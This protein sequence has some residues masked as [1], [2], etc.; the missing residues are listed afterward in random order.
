MS[1]NEEK[2]EKVV[3]RYDR[4][5]QRRQA[6]K[7][8]EKRSQ[9]ITKGVCGVIVL[10]V[11][12]FIASFPIRSYMATHEAYIT[13]NGEKV[14]RAEFDYNY[15]NTVNTYINQMGSYLGYMGLDVN[16]DFS[17]QEYADGLTWKDNFD[18]MTVEAL[19]TNKALKA[20]AEANGF[21]YDSSAE[22]EE[23]KSSLK[24]AA[25]EAGV[26]SGKYVKQVYGQYATV[27]AVEG[28]VRESA[29]L[30]AYSNYL[31]E[32]FAP[33]DEEIQ[34]YYDENSA[35]YET[36]SYYMSQFIAEVGDDATEE[37]IEN[38]MNDASSD[39]LEAVNDIVASGDY[40]ENQKKSDVDEAIVNWL[41]YEERQEGDQTVFPDEENHT[42]YALRFVNRQKDEES[43]VNAHVIMT[44]D[45]GQ[46]ILDEWSAGEATEASFINLW[47]EHSADTSMPDGLYKNIKSSGLDAE[48][49]GWLFDGARQAGDTSCI[50]VESTGTNYVVYYV[51]EGDPSWMADIKST[52]STDAKSNYINSLTENVTVEDPKGNLNYLKVQASNAAED[53]SGD[54]VVDEET[55]EDVSGDDVVDEETQGDVSANAAAEETGTEENVSES[56][57]A[58]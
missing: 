48:L 40:Y 4:K 1:D 44:Q 19:K 9:M 25:K 58:Q 23:F 22:A 13:V 12:A 41:F 51:G 15:N 52:L 45:D 14:T 46:A 24:D 32:K 55:Q 47:K 17:K 27:S 56:V 36:V 6:E 8:Q 21:T 50:S 38:A 54:D 2:K 29:M 26:S 7:E 28:Y 3:T 11:V 31:T 43:T 37:E 18:E 33:T 20:D 5:M 57:Q 49:S 34:S 42:Y 30:T 53:V 16:S 35:D 39:A 10:A